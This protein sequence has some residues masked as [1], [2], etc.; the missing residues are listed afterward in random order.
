MKETH[1]DSLIL[2]EKVNASLSDLLAENTTV[3]I[4][5]HGRGALATASFR[6]TASSHTQVNW[7]GMNINSPMTGMVDFSLIP[8][9]LIDDLDLKYGA[10]S[11]SDHGGGLGGSI[12]LNNKPHWKRRNYVKY[13]QGIGS[14]ST[15]EEFLDIG[16]GNNKFRSR[17][18]LYHNASK[19]DYTFLNRG[20][21]EIDPQSGEIVHSLDTNHNADYRI[22]G[23]L[24]ELYFKVD[25][26]NVLSARWW[27]QQADRTIPRATSYEGTD[28]RNL[29]R[30]QDLDNRIL[31]EW[32]RYLQKGKFMLR[33]GYAGKKLDYTLKNQV[34]GLGSIPLV[35]S[36]SH[37]KSFLNTASYEQ[38]IKPTL[39]FKAEIDLDLHHV[40]TK[41]TVSKSGYQKDRAEVSSL[42]GLQK[43]FRGR[44]NLNLMIRQNW[45]DWQDHQFIPFLGFDYLL[46][47]E[48]DLIL[49]GNIA[50]N[51]HRPALNDKYWQP[52]GNPDLKEEKGLGYEFGLEYRVEF[53]KHKIRSEL[54]FFHSEIDDWILWIPSY[55][56]YWEP[57]NIKR[58]TSKGLEL[59][60]F[61]EGAMGEF[62][63]KLNA[64]YAYTSSVNKGDALVWGDASY[65]KQLVYVPLHSGNLMLSLRW[66]KFHITYQHNAY[67]ERYTTSSNDISRRDWLYP[68]YMN[69]LMAGKEFRLG[70]ANLSAEFKI[71]NL[72][73]ETYHSVL[74]RPMPGRNYMFLIMVKI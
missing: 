28:N 27:W 29:N 55:K 31:L 8:V 66:K 44:L 4:K 47:K 13:I 20:I 41:D 50:R 40:D 67:S 1:I 37:L 42:L 61:L 17:T 58:V 36:E 73:D 24:Q 64:N 52:G 34:P 16:T 5:D 18:R 14:Y 74:Y 54:T 49:K 65:G 21:G 6:G 68:Y 39:N 38:K 51:Y 63:Y 15:F 70:K 48:Q 23:I 71:Y 60:V 7:N 62:K 12:N 11:I 43:N 9:Y 25:G 33:S 10:A 72:F 32:K 69:S 3:F 45:T 56:G 35:Y 2:M 59:S 22:Y 57:K 53:D 19:N 46:M 30:Q 26:Q